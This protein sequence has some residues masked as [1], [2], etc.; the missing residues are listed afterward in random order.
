MANREWFRVTPL[1]KKWRYSVTTRMISS[2]VMA[3]VCTA[4]TPLHLSFGLW[5]RE[6]FHLKAAK[7][8]LSTSSLFQM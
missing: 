5:N 6:T 1:L 8:R 3:R 2:F 4:E 7:R